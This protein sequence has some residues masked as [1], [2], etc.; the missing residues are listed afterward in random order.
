MSAVAERGKHLERAISEFAEALLGT[1]ARLYPKPI[2]PFKYSVP[3]GKDTVTVKFREPPKITAFFIPSYAGYLRVLMY[4]RGRTLRS[5]KLVFDGGVFNSASYEW[6]EK[7]GGP[8]RSTVEDALILLATPQVLRSLPSATVEYATGEGREWFEGF[9]GLL[10]EADRVRASPSD[11]LSRNFSVVAV[12][13]EI[14]NPLSW[15]DNVEIELTKKGE[16]EMKLS[17]KPYGLGLV[18]CNRSGELHI[19]GYYGVSVGRVRKYV[20]KL[21]DQGLCEKFAKAL[22]EFVRANVLAHIA[23][24]Y[25]SV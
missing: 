25:A 20:E 21:L 1:I 5:V 14:I 11:F 6:G 24:A 4:S 9:V 22:R 12:K 8:V 13:I 17:F 18:T 10:M 16:L 15:L 19:S 23:L 2:K 3:F 7:K